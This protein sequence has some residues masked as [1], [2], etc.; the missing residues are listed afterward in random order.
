VVEN[1]SKSR[2]QESPSTHTTLQLLR[3][4]Q[5]NDDSTDMNYWES[6]MLARENPRLTASPT[7]TGFAEIVSR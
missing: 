4:E 7:P 3:A 6:K 2:K 5:K 1:K